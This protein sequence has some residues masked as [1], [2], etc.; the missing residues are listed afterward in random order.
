M[1]YEGKHFPEQERQEEKERSSKFGWTIKQIFRYTFWGVCALVWGIILFRIFTSTDA[2]LFKQ[3]YFSDDAAVIAQKLD[4]DFTVYA[5]QT[6][7]T[8]NE[9]GTIQVRN[10]FYAEDAKEFEVGIRYRM[11]HFTGKKDTELPFTVVLKDNKGNEYDVC[12]VEFTT[13]NDYGFARVS[14]QGVEIDKTTNQYFFDDGDFSHETPDIDDSNG[15]VLNTRT[16]LF[17]Y[18][19][20]DG[21]EVAKLQVYHDFAILEEVDYKRGR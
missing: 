3:M 11:K 18:V 16:S 13:K 10:N 19:Y 7:S 8:M 6:A 2:R 4:D 12:N 20:Y 15:Q 5:L 14:F 21:E 9:D 1:D 17:L